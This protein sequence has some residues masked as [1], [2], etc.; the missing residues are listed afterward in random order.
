M[1]QRY[2]WRKKN[3]AYAKKNILPRVKHDGG[4]LMLWSCFASSGTGK[5]K[6]VEGKIDSV[7]YRLK[8]RH[9]VCDEAEAWASLDLPTGQ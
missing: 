9:A 4:S 7:K 1:D 2:V 3:E 5:L 6:R 8:K